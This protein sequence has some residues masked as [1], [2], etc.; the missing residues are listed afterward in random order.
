MIPH[1]VKT[2]TSTYQTYH[3]DFPPQ[4]V[5]LEVYPNLKKYFSAIFILGIATIRYIYY[6]ELSEDIE[7]FVI[8]IYKSIYS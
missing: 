8:R 3:D 7:Y 5:L 6:G 4:G 2:S 1:K